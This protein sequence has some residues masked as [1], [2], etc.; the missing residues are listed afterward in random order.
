M[1][2]IAFLFVRMVC[3]NARGRDEFVEARLRRILQTCTR[4]T[5]VDLLGNGPNR[6]IKHR[7]GRTTKTRG[8][9]ECA[10]DELRSRHG[11]RLYQ[12]GRTRKAF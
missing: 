5:V 4:S 9:D 8:H 11:Y 2:A 3:G 10:D 1:I 12:S 6:W 7:L